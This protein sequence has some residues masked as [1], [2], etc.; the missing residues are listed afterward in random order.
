MARVVARGE[1]WLY[2]FKPPDKRR[3]VV[4]LTRQEA[5]PFLNALI[6]APVTSTVRGSPGEVV[7]G[8]VEGLKQQSAANLDQ[9]QTVAKDRLVRYVGRVAPARMR[10][11]CRA[12]AI[13]TGCDE[14]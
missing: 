3:P 13:A 7:V 10:E 8:V 1:V 2:K 9:V 5:I 4:V 12:L 6:V 11:I 14:P